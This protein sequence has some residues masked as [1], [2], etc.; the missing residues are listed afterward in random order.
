MGFLDSFPPDIAIGFA[1]NGGTK[2]YLIE[3]ESTTGFVAWRLDDGTILV[4]PAETVDLPASPSLAFWPCDGYQ[5]TTPTG[6]I[7]SLDCHANQLT[8]LDVRG[9]KALRFLDCCYNWLT[10]LDLTGLA[11]LEVLDVDNN[12]LAM[13]E[14]LSL[15]SLRVL[16][17]A[18][19]RLA[20]LDVSSLAKL[21]VFDSSGN[22]FPSPQK[23]DSAH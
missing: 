17:C 11:D 23:S 19:N 21:Q 12:R 18:N 7:I 16:N 6:D 2:R 3:A 22:P 8:R 14:V 15:R 9:L 4:N 5:N 1:A 20:Q 13:L 10:E